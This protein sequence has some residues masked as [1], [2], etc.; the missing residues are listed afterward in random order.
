MKSIFIESGLAAEK[1]CIAHD[2]DSWTLGY[3]TFVGERGV[4]LSGGQRQR[5]GNARAFYKKVD[6]IVLDEATS[7][8]DNQTEASVMASIQTLNPEITVIII[9]HRLSSISGCDKIIE[10]SEGRIGWVG[11]YNQL[12]IKNQQNE[13]GN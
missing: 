13:Q 9:A 5:I 12:N 10:L 6:V 4:K 1:A 8:L 7:A 11:S 2:I 3:D